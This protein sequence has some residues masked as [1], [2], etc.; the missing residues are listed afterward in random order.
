MGY[1]VAM[2]IPQKGRR[3]TILLWGITEECEKSLDRYEGF[4]TLYRK[5]NL[6]FSALKWNSDHLPLPADGTVEAMIY[7]MNCDV[8]KPPFLGYFSC[9]LTGYRDA[10]FHRRYLDA[11]LKK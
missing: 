2:V 4:P 5:E 11:A 9:I 6:I 10:G 8:H 7:I 3:A 1:G